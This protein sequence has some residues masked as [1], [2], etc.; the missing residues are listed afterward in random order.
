MRNHVNLQGKLVSDA[1]LARQFRAGSVDDD[2]AAVERY[3]G[4]RG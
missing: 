4:P 1:F 3:A 2:D